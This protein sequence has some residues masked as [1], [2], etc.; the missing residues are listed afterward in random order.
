MY[1]DFVIIVQRTSFC[2][3][4]TTHEI[5]SYNTPSFAI[6]SKFLHR[7]PTVSESRKLSIHVVLTEASL[8]FGLCVEAAVAAS[9]V[10]AELAGSAG[11]VRVLTGG[12]LR[13]I[14]VITA[15]S[16][17]SA[18]NYNTK[19]T[20]HILYSIGHQTVRKTNAL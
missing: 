16:V 2:T 5:T 18:L 15:L 12:A 6:R 1:L 10:R 17:V 14:P 20:N 13:G 11:V 8:A 3:I 4:Y 7:F 9:G 19:N